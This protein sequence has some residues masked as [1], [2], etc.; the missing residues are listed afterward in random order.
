MVGLLDYCDS[1]P[2]RALGA[3]E[4]LIG[5]GATS[6]EMYVV[7]SGA[8]V[9]SLAGQTLAVVTEPGAVFGEMSALLDGPTGATV[10][11]AEGTDGAEVVVVD[12]PL[13]FMIE[14]P[15]ALL[16]IART[17]AGRLGASSA[18]LSD[19]Q[20]QYG[21]Q[22]GNLGLIDEVLAKLAFGTQQPAEPG[23]MRDPD[24]EY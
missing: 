17:L 18:Y 16:F 22:S 14:R 24:P 5:E 12:H 1:Y 21:A 3:G 9:V 13:A 10:T 15:D 11:V 19:L 4:V 20:R 8:F 6:D 7:V 2:H 23:S